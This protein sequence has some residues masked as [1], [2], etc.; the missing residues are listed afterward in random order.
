MRWCKNCVLP[1]TRPNLRINSSGICNA[2]INHKSKDVIN[3]NEREDK[4]KKICRE[5]QKRSKG[6][7]CLVPVSGG[8][9][10]TWQTIKLIELGLNPLAITWKPPGRTKIGQEN[11]NNLINIGVDHIDYSINPYVEAKFMLAAFKKFGAT[12]IPMHQAL[13]NI[14]LK[15]AHKFEIPLVIYGENGAFEYGNKSEEDTGFQINWD[16][17]KTYGVTFG[18]S[19]EDWISPN[20]TRNELT[21]Y[22]GPSDHVIEKA[23]ILGVFLGYYFNWDPIE[24][25]RVA[26]QNGFKN[27]PSG[28]RT[29]LYDFADIDDIFISIHHWIK[30]YKFGFSRLFDNLSIEIRNH[31]ITRE[32]A[33]S[34]IVEE[35]N[36][37]PKK[38]ILEFA[39]FCK[40]D[41][42]E[43]YDIAES[44]RNLN[45][46]EK[47]SNN[48]WYMPNF[49]VK[50]WDWSS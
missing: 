31:R 33:I 39:K 37:T 14:P 13:F 4:F 7:D 3:W 24:S 34:I 40:I 19:A 18:T 47:D 49:L 29:G 36:Q 50:D 43:I 25:K 28:P 48:N 20:L 23:G 27:D 2:C 46:W 26:M 8:K 5:A 9:D 15:I 22:F 45:I 35:G 16:W 11:L 38:E 17:M 10:S 42:K 44:F 30:W 12:A 6:Y 1:D 21:P 41:S 32:K